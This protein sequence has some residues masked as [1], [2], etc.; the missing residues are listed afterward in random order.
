MKHYWTLSALTLLTLGFAC[1]NKDCPNK[2]D[3]VQPGENPPNY[4]VII[5]PEGFSQQATVRFGQETAVTR[6]GAGT[7]IIAKVPAGLRGSVEISL[8]END[9]VGRSNFIV[10]DS[11][12]GAYGLSLQYVVLPSVPQTPPS[13]IGNGW[14]NA[15]DAQ[16]RF[17]LAD[18]TGL[19]GSRYI[20]EEASTEQHDTN[21]KLNGNPV[22]GSWS[23]NPN[24][25]HLVVDRT[26]NGGVVE[27]FDGQFIN[28]YPS[29]SS[30]N[31]FMLLTSKIT[32]R[33][34]V[35]YATF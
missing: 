10:L 34:L 20:S 18:S 21:L 29:A 4:E 8:E 15:V 9:C 3:L 31:T 5:H 19:D 28:S 35:L 23:V 17:F 32:G 13:A 16:H 7:D 2:V 6:P 11:L 27:A 1:K 24:K 33:Q 26:Q 30:G 25:V 14:T 12:P 22:K